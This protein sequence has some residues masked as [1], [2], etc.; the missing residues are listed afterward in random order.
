MG[1][2]GLVA[3]VLWMTVILTVILLIFSIRNMK[4]YTQVSR[5]ILIADKWMPSR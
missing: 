2:R 3:E 5:T 1:G 4:T